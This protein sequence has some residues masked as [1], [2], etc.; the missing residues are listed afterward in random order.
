MLYRKLLPDQ[1][2]I[3]LMLG[4]PQT[5]VRKQIIQ[6]FGLDIS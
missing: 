3:L 1:S 4:I 5:H 2:T 6:E